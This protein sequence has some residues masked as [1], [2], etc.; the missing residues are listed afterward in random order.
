MPMARTN[1]IPSRERARSKIAKESR[2]S[3]SFQSTLC[4]LQGP[5]E[6]RCC[7]KGNDP[8]VKDTADLVTLQIFKPGDCPQVLQ[9]RLLSESSDWKMDIDNCHIGYLLK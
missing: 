8:Y 9:M 3:I 6:F 4:S 7:I 2:Y 1:R 5:S